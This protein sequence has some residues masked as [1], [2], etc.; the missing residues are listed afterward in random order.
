MAAAFGFGRFVYTPILPHMIA[1]G[2]SPT[3]AG[4]VAAVN[5]FGYLAGAVAGVTGIMGGNA[6][7]WF[8]GGLAASGLTMIAMAFT[9]N[10]WAFSVLRFVG[11]A[12]GAIIM[13]A[14]ASLVFGPLVIAERGR[15]ALAPFFGPGLGIAGSS[16]LVALLAGAG[17]SWQAMWIVTG[18]IA[19]AATLA[20]VACLPSRSEQAIVG[21]GVQSGHVHWSRKLAL[22]TLSYGLFG[23]GYVITA[24]FIVVITRETP[25]LRFLEPFVW[26]IVGVSAAASIPFWSIVTRR[27]GELPTYVLGCMV[28]GAGVALSVIDPNPVGIVLAA[29]FVGGTFVAITAIGLQIGRRLAGGAPQKI[30]AI[31]TVAFGIGQVVGPLVAGTL[32]ESSGSF[33]AASLAAAAALAVA[34]ALA[35]VP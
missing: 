18:A 25:T 13:V 7:A 26:T 9:G 3:A 6:R 27:F 2:L 30:Q 28:E 1:D 12:G 15:Y 24:T 4:F 23:F 11:G 10:V 16:L 35:L 32:R 5:Y 34:A 31:M 29:V 21:G 17:A 33:L 22:L 20:V 8:V 19:S 14:G